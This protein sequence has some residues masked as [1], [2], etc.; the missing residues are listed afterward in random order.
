[1][2]CDLK[3]NPVDVIKNTQW[4]PLA[5]TKSKKGERLSRSPTPAAEVMAVRQDTMKKPTL[6]TTV[7]ES[8]LRRFCHEDFKRSKDSNS[9][10]VAA[11]DD[12]VDEEGGRDEG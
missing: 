12:A 8:P 5:A 10:P 9:N 7:E 6:C 2:S 4:I 1:M 3:M 11:E